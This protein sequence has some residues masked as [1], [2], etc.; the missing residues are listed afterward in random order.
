[1]PSVST[2]PETVTARQLFDAYLTTH[3]NGTVEENSLATLR[4]HLARVAE[5][6]GDRFRIQALTLQNLQAHVERRR[7]K[8]IAPITLRK[9]LATLRA[10]WNWA[11]HGKLINGSFPG[12]GL[13]LPKEN[14]KEPFRSFAEITTVVAAEKPSEA[15][16]DAPLGVPVPD[17]GLCYAL[18]LLRWGG[19]A[20]QSFCSSS[21]N[22]TP[23]RSKAPDPARGG[24]VLN[25]RPGERDSALGLPDGRVRG[26]H[27]VPPERDAAGGR[28]R[29]RLGRRH[30]D[31]PGKEAGAGE[32]V[33][34]GRAAVADADRGAA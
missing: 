24:R 10:C 25:P 15:R 6:V 21:L 4:Q 11:T 9:E 18:A 29:C 19:V 27:R 26:V 2:R 23:M 20:F 7:K 8:G 32:A 22:K 13:R 5:S 30:G 3:A 14:E 28:D 31:R 12:K 17:P 34:P 33:A 1:M 16:T